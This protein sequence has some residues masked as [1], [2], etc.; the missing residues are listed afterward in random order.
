VTSFAVLA[1]DEGRSVVA[2][3]RSDAKPAV[4]NPVTED[5]IAQTVAEQ[6]GIA[7]RDVNVQTRGRMP[8][9]DH[10]ISLYG[11]ID[12]PGGDSML[13]VFAHTYDPG[14]GTHR[15]LP[16]CDADFN[17]DGPHP[18][19]AYVGDCSVTTLAGG[20]VLVVRSGVAPGGYARATAQLFRPDWSGL[21][22]ES[23]NQD[24]VDPKT[25]V[26]TAHSKECPAAPITRADTGV[27]A[28]A[29]GDLLVALEPA[30]R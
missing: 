11:A 27:T 21:T 17:T 15:P 25:C 4:P 26:E 19:S 2:A 9:G 7:F 18:E 20:A 28:Q 3:P 12:D 6:L 8:S 23:T 14:G 24:T 1:R 5:N 16:G 10:G 22:A 29:L 13:R 30:T